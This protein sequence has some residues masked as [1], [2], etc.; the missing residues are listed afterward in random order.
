MT[1]AL[2][3]SNRISNKI[4]N[5]LQM[6]SFFRFFIFSRV[7]AFGV[8]W[9]RTYIGIYKNKYLSSRKTEQMIN[10]DRNSLRKVSFSSTICLCCLQITFIIGDVYTSAMD[11]LP[12]NINLDI[13]QSFQQEM[14][15]NKCIEFQLKY[16]RGT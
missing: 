5:L 12:S 16:S 11:R 2:T 1:Y 8:N 4:L 14:E 3:I 13:L 7:T 10:E 15:L 9:I 6:W